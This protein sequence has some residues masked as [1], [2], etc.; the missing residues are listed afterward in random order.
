MKMNKG[1]F[2]IGLRGSLRAYQVHWSEL[3][4]THSGDT[5]LPSGTTNKVIPNFGTGLYF[6]SKRF[7]IGVSLPHI[8][9]R[10]LSY[11]EIA[12][13]TDFGKERRHFYL[14]S[15]YLLNLNSQVKFKPA[16][17]LKYVKNTPFD[18]DL[19]TTFIFMDK[20]WTGLSYRL[21]GDSVQGIG[22]SIDLLVQYQITSE[23]RVGAAYDF[24]LSKL[25][26]HSSGSY[27]VQ[28]DYC[29]Q[30]K[31]RKDQRLTNPRFF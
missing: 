13:N 8:L 2:S 19:N 6:D 11:S 25:R 29:I 23:F 5:E 24:T 21:G 28:L 7:Y 27:E 10:D 15:G 18:M 20:W 4:A 3:S 30:T 31:K 22:E 14:M 12:R 1:T 9:N 26:N 17:L 16:I